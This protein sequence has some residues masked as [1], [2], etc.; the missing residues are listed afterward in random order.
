[1]FGKGKP[2]LF[3]RDVQDLKLTGFH[4]S[5]LFLHVMSRGGKNARRAEVVWP[6]SIAKAG[7]L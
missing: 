3:G 1:L 5:A 4:A 6:F 7:C 2:H